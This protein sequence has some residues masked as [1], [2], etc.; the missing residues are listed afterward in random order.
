MRRLLALCLWIATLTAA[1][2]KSLTILHSN[3]L[4]S[5][6]MPN[7]EGRGGFARLATAV[8]KERANCSACLYLNA[9]DLVQGSPVSSIYEGVP[10]YRMA[11]LLGF[12]AGTLGN[13]EFDYGWRR[14]RQ[15]ARIARFPI[16]SANVVDQNGKSITGKPYVIK[17]V[18]GLRV[19]IIGVVLGELV[20]RA[21]VSAASVEPWKVLPVVDT[22]RRYASQIKDK[23]DVIVVLGHLH[24]KE[25]VEAILHEVP[26]VAIVVAGHSHTGYPQMMNVDGRV[27]VL[28][29]AY[30]V[31]LG[32][33]DLKI[34][35]EAKTAHSAEW[36]KIP[37]DSRLSD[38]PRMTYAV[39]KWE[40]KISSL[41]D[42]PIGVA[43]Q[44]LDHDAQVKLFE[45]AMLETTKADFV[46]FDPA[47]A[48]NQ[49]DI[50]PGQ[51]MAR[52]IWEI[53]PYDNQVVMGKF[54]GSQLPA[55]VVKS[56]SIDPDREYSLATTDFTAT[57]QSAP[58][59]LGT[60]GLEFKVIG[61]AQ[62][63]LILNWI[64]QKRTIP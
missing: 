51:V 7:S 25:E 40:D 2:L 31:E 17:N 21:F 63:D 36:S 18:G 35:P 14:T 57:N 56:K 38:A 45:Q 27:A 43:T 8:Q 46:F 39:K 60:T 24:D 64:K 3:D 26:E 10:I 32:R 23:T 15:F 59:Q 11:N 37:I 9:G 4:H 41:V 52:Q 20:S 6:S 54:K 53:F 29:Q 55:K 50:K 13:H 34:D 12:D 22:V 42:V 1:D 61:R 48:R 30:G 62:R 49:H 44:Y 28:L 47:S 5:Q 19:G 58:T 16:V 33:L